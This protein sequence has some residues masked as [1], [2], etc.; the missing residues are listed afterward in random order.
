[1]KLIW[2]ASGYA[3]GR[4]PGRVGSRYDSRL[5]DVASE[6]NLRLSLA[7]G[8]AS[9][10][11]IDLLITPLLPVLVPLLLALGLAAAVER[12]AHRALFVA[13]R[14]DPDTLLLAPDGGAVARPI[15]ALVRAQGF[16]VSDT[17]V[18]LAILLFA[19]T[20][21]GGLFLVR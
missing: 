13:R 1:V 9:M 7:S 6:I 11:P 2:I 18:L 17:G 12:R 16:L 15:P 4:A 19:A 21:I 5:R 10:R 8:P 14:G 3:P 20:G